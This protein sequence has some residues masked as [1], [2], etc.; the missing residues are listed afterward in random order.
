MSRDEA[1]LLDILTAARKILLFTD[2]VTWEQF[3]QD[4]ILQ[5]AVIRWLE[6]IGEAARSLSDETKNTHPGIPWR[7]MIGMRN[8]LIHHSAWI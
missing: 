8:R 1:Y 6:I 3:E 4:E 5:N 7:G 2:S